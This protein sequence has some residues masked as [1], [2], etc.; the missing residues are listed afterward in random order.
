M[1]TNNW[2][3]CTC[4][5][6]CTLYFHTNKGSSAGWKNYVTLSKSSGTCLNY[7]M[8]LV[9][10]KYFFLNFPVWLVCYAHVFHVHVHVFPHILDSLF[11]SL[12]KSDLVLS[13]CQFDGQHVVARRRCKNA[14]CFGDSSDLWGRRVVRRRGRVKRSD[15]R[16]NQ[17]HEYSVI[18]FKLTTMILLSNGHSSL[19]YI[20]RFGPQAFVSHRAYIHNWRVTFQLCIYAR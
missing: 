16:N 1:N 11:L 2:T 15:L 13:C 19:Q 6:L 5:L 10:R 17:I 7:S 14:G 18:S 8:K 12:Q 20:G 4:L 9:Q 3:K